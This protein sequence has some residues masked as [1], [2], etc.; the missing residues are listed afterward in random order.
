MCQIAQVALRNSGALLLLSEEP[1][2]VLYNAF[3]SAFASIHGVEEH[4]QW[5]A[6]SK[7]NMAA[8]MTALARV[9]NLVIGAAQPFV[10]D[11]AMTLWPGRSK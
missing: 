7:D 9:S 6:L 8:H 11:S 4:G 10:K 2:R 5:A 1:D 3:I